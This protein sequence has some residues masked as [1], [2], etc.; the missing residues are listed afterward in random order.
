MSTDPRGA[1]CIPPSWTALHPA[2]VSLEHRRPS[3]AV[4]PSSRSSAFGCES[5]AD[6]L[7]AIAQTR[8]SP[9]AARRRVGPQQAEAGKLAV[10]GFGPGEPADPNDGF[11]ESVSIPGGRRDD[12]SELSSRF[13]RPVACFRNDGTSPIHVR[14]L[15]GRDPGPPPP[16]CDPVCARPATPR[17][18]TAPLKTKERAT[19]AFEPATGASRRR[20]G[21][22]GALPT[23]DR[24][25]TCGGRGSFRTDRTG[26]GIPCGPDH[27]ARCPR[28]ETG[29]GGDD[30]LSRKCRRCHTHAGER[31]DFSF[32]L[33]PFER[34]TES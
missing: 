11:G 18:R 25:G 31:R 33:Q 6:V 19:S 2:L 30:N 34:T 28:Q 24:A 21:R 20:S 8:V 9:A 16:V 22:D 4:P 32:A 7:P 3:R 27:P 5:R 10:A 13:G 23:D 1:T 29:R 14:P 15:Q 12:F 26:R 17:S